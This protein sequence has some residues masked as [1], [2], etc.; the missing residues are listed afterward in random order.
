MVLALAAATDDS[1]LRVFFDFALQLWWFWLLIAAVGLVRLAHTLYARR[2]LAR[3]G[4]TKI[5][6]MDGRTFEQYLQTTGI[7][8]E[9][10]RTMPERSSFLPPV[11]ASSSPAAEPASA[12]GCPYHKRRTGSLAGNPRTRQPSTMSHVPQTRAPRTVVRALARSRPGG[13]VL[14]RR[15]PGDRFAG[16]W[17]LPGGTVEAGESLERALARELREEAGLAPLKPPT[18][19]ST[20]S[21]SRRALG[22][23]GLLAGAFRDRRRTRSVQVEPHSDR[24]VQF[25]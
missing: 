3:S 14:L 8:L 6:R 13:Y 11:M 18:L 12:Y 1:P 10:R 24:D 23:L 20:E 25:V 19:I 9:P 16:H 22:A 17:E 7:R 4:I 21:S 5:D 15:A 2:R